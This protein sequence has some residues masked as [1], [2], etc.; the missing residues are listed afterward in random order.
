MSFYMYMLE[1]SDHSIYTGHSDNLE[2]RLS[3]HNDGRFRG[4][5]YDRCPVRL[6]FHEPFATREEAFAAERQVKGWSRE[7]KLALARR[8]WEVLKELSVRRTPRRW[9]AERGGPAH[10]SSEPQDEREAASS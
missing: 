3:A 6:L 7:K 10:P 2:A 1:C 4:Y 5:T 9:L 8:D